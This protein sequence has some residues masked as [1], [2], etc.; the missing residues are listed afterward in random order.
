MIR[1]RADKKPLLPG[2]KRRTVAGKGGAGKMRGDLENK[3][4]D[5]FRERSE[6][7]AVYLFGSQARGDAREKSDV[8]VAVI[9]DASL[10]RD[11][12]EAFRR[13]CGYSVDLEGWLKKPA[14]VV[15]LDQCSP[16]LA[17]YALKDAR[18]VLDRDRDRRLAVVT[19]QMAMHHDL[20]PGRE[21]YLRRVME[22]LVR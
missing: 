4:Y 16:V 7:A 2:E 3:L 22:G 18:L 1:R 19:R 10:A 21:Q 20:A 17:H 9:F 12:L 11:R 6:V 8:D 5:F 15:D 14:D 13:R